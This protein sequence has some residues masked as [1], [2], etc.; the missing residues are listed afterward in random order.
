[1][2]L[3][4][5][6]T[7]KNGKARK[8][9]CF[10]A[11]SGILDCKAPGLPGYGTNELARERNAMNPMYFDLPEAFDTVSH[12]IRITK[13]TETYVATRTTQALNR[14]E[15][16]TLAICTSMMKKRTTRNSVQK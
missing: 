8:K 12:E 10:P 6:N 4:K 9:S 16:K 13:S 15:R 3:K 14:L 1:M 5:R 7:E 2:L 11:L